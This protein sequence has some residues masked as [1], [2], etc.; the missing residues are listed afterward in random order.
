MSAQTKCEERKIRTT[1][2]F[3][4]AYYIWKSII[5][6]NSTLEALGVS[7]EEQ[8]KR[9]FIH[10]E[11]F[12][13]AL[14][15]DDSLF[16]YGMN[17]TIERLDFPNLYI[18]YEYY[19]ARKEKNLTGEGAMHYVPFAIP[20]RLPGRTTI[21]GNA[22]VYQMNYHS[23]FDTDGL[24]PSN[25]TGSNFSFCTSKRY[26]ELTSEFYSRDNFTLGTYTCLD[27]G[28]ILSGISNLE[29]FGEFNATLTHCSIALAS[30][31]YI[32]TNFESETR[33]KISPSEQGNAT[34]EPSILRPLRLI[35]SGTTGNNFEHTARS[36][37]LPDEFIIRSYPMMYLADM[38]ENTLYS[39]NARDFLL[40][41]RNTSGTWSAVI[42]DIGKVVGEYIRSSGNLD[43]R[44]MTGI[45][46]APQAFIKVEWVWLV[47]PLSLTVLSVGFLMLTIIQS[48]D[49]TYLYKTSILAATLHGLEGWSAE[50]MRGCGE[51]V[52][53]KDL[54]D[55][56]RGMKAQ[57]MSEDG[58]SVRFVRRS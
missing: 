30:A 3:G 16:K 7:E 13:D 47:L 39:D 36:D 57:I 34:A 58:E 26:G 45:A 41:R 46:W 23:Y 2:D 14:R 51:K 50:E 24:E 49:K 32:N 38:I 22:D 31:E 37:D 53:E 15:D 9:R 54:V 48:R 8:H 52:S 42:E 19:P 20:S 10:L 40:Q 17:C 43:A 44:N 1:A 5:E 4:C 35:K 29:S 12:K 21:F 56:T 28:R 55:M 6:V 25:V 27:T 11:D 18:N 33:D